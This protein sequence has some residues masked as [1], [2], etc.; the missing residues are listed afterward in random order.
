[1][2]LSIRLK[3]LIIMLVLLIGILISAVYIPSI[4][5]NDFYHYVK[6]EDA[7][8]LIVDFADRNLASHPDKTTAIYNEI[9]N[10]S[11]NNNLFIEVYRFQNYVSLFGPNYNMVIQG[12]NGETYKIHFDKYL[13]YDNRFELL[14]ADPDAI[15]I[16]GYLINSDTI[17]PISIN[18]Y[19]LALASAKYYRVHFLEGNFKSLK[20]SLVEFEYPDRTQGKIYQS[21]V[22]DYL[23]RNGNGES[24][25]GRD[26]LL[27]YEYYDLDTGIEHHMIT[28]EKNTYIASALYSFVPNSDEDHYRILFT[29]MI[30][31]IGIILVFTI[32][33]LIS[34]QVTN[35]ILRLNQVAKRMSDLDFSEKLPSKNYD[36]IQTLASSLNALSTKLETHIH[37]L[38]DVNERLHS[39]LEKEKVLESIRKQFI[40]DSSHELKTPL[41]IIRAYAERMQDTLI[42]GAGDKQIYLLECTGILLDEVRHIDHLIVKL[43]ELAKLDSPL[44]GL[45]YK[46]VI[47][48]PIIM[49]QLERLDYMIDAKDLD[50]KVQIS[51]DFPIYADEANITS[52]ISN[53]ITNAVV[54]SDEGSQI[55]LNYN[56]RFSISNPCDYLSDED[57]A[58]LWDRFYRADPSRNRNKG[59]SG[60]GLSIVKTILEKHGFVF[61][62]NYNGEVIEFY[63]DTTTSHKPS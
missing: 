1:M 36:E 58:H 44:H 28:Y 4:Y 45:S 17:Y 27:Y 2:K 54:Y 48:E 39:E 23:I 53:L 5:F 40:A 31:I 42:K 37:D 41:G 3:L 34:R 50:V 60:L 33:L 49:H 18:G 35:P 9:D 12:N 62:L 22:S 57:L 16:D 25:D 26:D 7:I 63:F 8:D 47:F 6:R 21:T 56:G 46:P 29:H 30:S 32:S 59:G 61:G 51:H 55:I 15:Q 14:F 10:L 38:N 11:R 13:L 19:N 20:G 43:N 24:I 52:A